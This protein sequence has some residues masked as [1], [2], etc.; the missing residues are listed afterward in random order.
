M[1]LAHL[2]RVAAQQ[3]IEVGPVQRPRKALQGGHA[4]PHLG[5]AG[6]AHES[7]VGLLDVHQCRARVHQQ[8]HLRQL[9]VAFFVRLIAGSGARRR[10]PP[11][12]QQAAGKHILRRVRF[13]D[14]H[15]INI[16]L[17]GKQVVGGALA[18]ETGRQRDV[19]D[20]HRNHMARSRPER[21]PQAARGSA[22]LQTLP[23]ALVPIARGRALRQE[24]IEL[25]PRPFVDDKLTKAAPGEVLSA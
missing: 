16:L 17:Q 12:L 9:V 10:G 23:L 5:L 21:H 25:F 14:R 1:G 3:G 7:Q 24:A 8:G 20:V 2:P 19:E 11:R 4:H 15:G 18:I 22:A 6:L 13:W